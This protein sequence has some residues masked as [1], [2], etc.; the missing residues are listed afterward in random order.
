[1]K[2][3]LPLVVTLLLVVF[4]SSVM[5]KNGGLFRLNIIYPSTVKFMMT[6]EVLLQMQQMRWH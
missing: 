4:N 6:N 3:L 1:M 5:A 2:L